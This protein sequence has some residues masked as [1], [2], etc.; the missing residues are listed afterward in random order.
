MSL[1]VNNCRRHVVG[2]LALAA[3]LGMLNA[4]GASAETYSVKTTAELTAAVAKVNANTE[5]NKIVLEGGSYTPLKSLVL[6]NTSGAL[7]IEGPAGSPATKGRAATI[8]GSSVEPT[9]A[10]LFVVDGGVS[11]TL[12]NLEIGNAGGL[13]NAAI[14]VVPKGNLTIQSSSLEG[15]TGSGVLV[16]D[17][18]TL[19][20]RNS[21]VSDG[22]E[23]GI[24]DDGTASFFNATVAFNTDGGIQNGGTLDL[25]NTIVAENTGS[26]GS[27]C[28]LTGTTTSDHSLDSDGSCH[29]GALSDANPLLQANLLNNGG[30]TPVH[31]LKPGSP[32]IG[33]GDETQ[34]PATDQRGAKRANPCSIGADEY[35]STPPTITVPA[36]IVVE[37]EGSEQAVVSYTPEPTAVG[38]ENAIRT[39][40][41]APASGSTFPKG[42][43]AVKC[44][45]VDGHENTATKSFNVKVTSKSVAPVAPTVV[46]TAA[47]AVTQTSATLNATV[48]PNGGDVT[49]CEFEYG[50]STSYGKTVAC[51]TLPGSGTSA[52]SV[53]ASLSGLSA[54]TPYDFRISATN[55]TGT[56]KGLNETFK[57]LPNAPTVVTGSASSIAQTT[58]TLNATVNPNGGN[59]TECEFEYGTSTSYGSTASCSSLP[60]SGTSAVAGSG[61]LTGLTANTTYHF[62]ISATNAGGT[63]KGSDATFTTL[64]PAP[65]VVTGSA[66]SVTQTSATL[67]ATVNPNGAN[68]SAC[69]FEYGTSTSYGK[70]VACTTLPGDGTS[71]VS[72]SAPLTG[73]TANTTYHFRTS[74]TNAG[75][76]SKGSDATFTTPA[77]VAPTV[78]TGAGTA[79]AQTSATLNATVNPN[80][81]NVTGCEFEYG[82]TVSY[83]SSVSCASLPGSGTSA[84]AVSASL[85]G[86]AANTTYHFRISATNASG[87]SKGSDATFTTAEEP[88]VEPK[89]ESKVEPKVEPKV[90][91]PPSVTK[92]E[93]A[94]DVA[95]AVNSTTVSAQGAFALK[96]SCPEED[97]S[98]SGTV[99]VHTLTAVLASRGY[100]AKSKKRKAAILTLASGSFTLSG[101]QVKVLTLHLSSKARSLLSSTK[102]LRVRVT[103]VA[104][105][106]TGATHTNQETVTLRAARAR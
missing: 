42:T 38:V 35:N 12:K 13:G 76:T 44:T 104:H 77:P 45:A 78:L 95:L 55:A 43:T 51:S 67:S 105:D 71:A 28:V 92:Q 98:C 73:L 16:G 97:E 19:T 100:E 20:V 88:K 61:S 27:D 79:I 40:S 15:N 22:S 59:V 68:V 50:T 82:A 106:A 62:R 65:T 23:F 81:G 66:S 83:G 96:L 91:V 34:C 11:V 25:T 3:G 21:T 1:K 56:S 2:L 63:S 84:V 30:T 9:F 89:T 29:V 80:D 58:A 99:T 85:T 6:T 17:E 72:V 53:S 10:Q 70:T 74:T 69:E 75:G 18:G 46:T 86:L 31:S 24:L 5:T 36:E 52:V 39:F 8:V 93:P 101:G 14:E 26:G 41:C 37:E 32:A 102:V 33:A 7:T 47:T 57:T 90:E 48:N 60:G 49:T 64:P 103:I 4:P 87:T 54:N 94:P